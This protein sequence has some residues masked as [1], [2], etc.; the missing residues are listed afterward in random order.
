MPCCSLYTE[1]DLLKN[2][3]QSLHHPMYCVAYRDSFHLSLLNSI[4]SI[5]SIDVCSRFGQKKYFVEEHNNWFLAKS[6]P[7]DLSFPKGDNTCHQHQMCGHIWSSHRPQDISL[8]SRIL[9][10]RPIFESDLNQ[11][12]L[13]LKSLILSIV[14]SFS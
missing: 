8:G 14:H 11:F 7:G 4:A 9:K 1:H 6:T 13:T 12:L 5:T 3:N 2:H 10:C